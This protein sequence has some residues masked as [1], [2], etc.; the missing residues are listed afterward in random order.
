MAGTLENDELRVRNAVCQHARGSR[1]RGAVMLADDDQRGP[2]D[3]AQ[4]GDEVEVKVLRVDAKDRKIGLS[5]KNLYGGVTEEE[6]AALDANQAK[7]PPE[8]SADADDTGKDKPTRELRGGTG[9]AG[10]LIQ[11]PS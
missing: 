9:T 3:T 4:V 10:P 7:V 11:M 1:G 5:R 8:D 6:L 2:V